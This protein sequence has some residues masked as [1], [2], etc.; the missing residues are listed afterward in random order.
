MDK[1]CIEKEGKTVYPKTCRAV[2]KVN[3]KNIAVKFRRILF[4]N[5]DLEEM[6]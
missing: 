3:W 5:N 4:P 1:T 6:A 2:R